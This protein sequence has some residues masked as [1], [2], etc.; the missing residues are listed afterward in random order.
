MAEKQATKK[1]EQKSTKRTTRKPST[2]FSAEER[3]AMRE[4]VK[5]M[6]ADAQKADGER[7]VLGKIAEMEPSD[8][9]LAERIHAI[10]K[11]SA[12]ELSP[13]TWYGMPAYAKDGKVLFY[14]R[15]ARKFKE[16]YAMFGF[17]DNAT[18]DDGTMWPV[19]F[20]LTALTADVEARIADLVRKAVG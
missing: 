7:D 15:D 17:N 18:L 5:E 20:A 4:R 1:S 16:R 3:A 13:R 11:D 9:A 8:R 14:F 12:P 19:A 2:G 6:K 10:V